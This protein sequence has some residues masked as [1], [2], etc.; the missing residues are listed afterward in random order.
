MRIRTA[1]ICVAVAGAFLVPA[2]GTMA[3]TAPSGTRV[4][5][6]APADAP[7]AQA[8]PRRPLKRL[9]I[10]PRY[11]AG[12]DDVY[13]SYYPGPN[14]VR[15]CNATYVEEFRPSGPVIT[16]RMHCFWRPG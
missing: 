5:R 14:A 4:P 10:Y 12:P 6:A 7:A 9:R 13:P 3:Q 8:R 15:E 2:S 11:E 16:P 1:A